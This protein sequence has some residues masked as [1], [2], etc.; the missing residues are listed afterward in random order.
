[1][2]VTRVDA[3]AGFRPEDRVLVIISDT[4]IHGTTRLQTY[5][6]LLYKQYGRELSELSDNLPALKFYDDWKP[7]R[8]GPFSRNLSNDIEKCVG[9]R[10]ICKETVDPDRK[11]YRYALTIKGRAQW[12]KM[13][14]RF[15]SEIGAMREKISYMQTIRL[16]LLVKEIYRAY[17][18]YA[19]HSK[20]KDRF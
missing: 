16:E 8:Y 6:F 19:A 3:E 4:T 11:I 9:D 7:L 15:T 18:E 1:M 13:M 10:T 12:R 17:P 2:A 20:N 5:G 14:N